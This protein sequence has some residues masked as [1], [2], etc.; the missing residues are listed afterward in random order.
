MSELPASH[1][2]DPQEPSSVVGEIL[3]E[4]AQFYL[5][6]QPTEGTIYEFGPPDPS[7][8]R[9]DVRRLWQ[10]RTRKQDETQFN[11]DFAEIERRIAES[12]AEALII[13]QKAARAEAR[14]VQS[15]EVI[16]SQNPA[17]PTA[18][19]ELGATGIRGLFR[20]KQS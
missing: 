9:R 12:G 15:Q 8:F 4:A 14:L 18:T 17:A 1:N 19:K 11:I 6:D 13:Q 3:L 10:Q 20:R 5:L 2:H 7:K 16:P